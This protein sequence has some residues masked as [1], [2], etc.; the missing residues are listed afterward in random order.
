MNCKL[1]VRLKTAN[2]PLILCDK[3]KNQFLRSNWLIRG[4]LRA[5]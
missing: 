4:M 1:V 5:A 2:Y 3:P